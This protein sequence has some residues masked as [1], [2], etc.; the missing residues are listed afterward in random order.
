[1]ALKLSSR[2]VAFSQWL[3]S[4][5]IIERTGNLAALRR[6]LMLDEE[7]LFALY[8]YI[9]PHFLA[10]L[11]PWEE[12]VYLMTASLFAFH[13]L[14]H[15]E[16]D[17]SGEPANFGGSFRLLA[18]KKAASKEEQNQQ[19]QQNVELANTIKRRFEI[20]IS[21]RKEELFGHLR[22]A[23]RL[24]KRE[25]IPIHWALLLDDLRHWETEENHVQLRWS[26]SFYVGDKKT[27]GEKTNVS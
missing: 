18:L 27:E 24:L 1:M 21:C 9:P 3:S 5:V 17:A 22:Q 25:D 4:L 23:I 15:S 12:K 8:S 16:G 26:R 13:P 19:D 2:A 11:R 20:L 14:S 10:G 6:G 7:Q